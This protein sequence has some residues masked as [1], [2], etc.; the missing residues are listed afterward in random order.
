MFQEAILSTSVFVLQLE[1]TPRLNIPGTFLDVS[2]FGSGRCLKRNTHLAVVVKSVLGSIL[3]EFTTHFR[4][5]IFVGIG[6]FTG[7]TIWV[8]THDHLPGEDPR[9]LGTSHWPEDGDVAGRRVDL[10]A[11]VHEVHPEGAAFFLFPPF[12]PL[13]VFFLFYLF[14]SFFGSFFGCV[15]V[16]PFSF[17]GGSQ[18]AV[19]QKGYTNMVPW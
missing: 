10:R 2:L 6:M 17:F 15:F 19:A 8:L 11:G 18:V 12:F 13:C 7:G 1:Q 3:G 9:T 4:E 16:F 5:P 14:S